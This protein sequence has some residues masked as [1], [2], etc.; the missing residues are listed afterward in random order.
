[1]NINNLNIILILS[2]LIF[3]SGIMSDVVLLLLCSK[4]NLIFSYCVGK[5][6]PGI[7]VFLIL[8]RSFEPLILNFKKIFGVQCELQ[9]CC[10]ELSGKD[11]LKG[12]NVLSGIKH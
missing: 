4:E 6:H 7:F 11:P 12:L 1:M 10:E 2:M 8:L 5:C 9:V 3:L